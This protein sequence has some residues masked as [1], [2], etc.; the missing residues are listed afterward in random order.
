[1]IKVLVTLS[2]NQRKKIQS[3]Y[4]NKVSVRLYLSYEKIEK[5]GEFTLLLTKKQKDLIDTN[6]AVGKGAILELTYEQLERNHK[7]G[8]IQLLL[9]G[10]GAGSAIYSAIR[11][12]RHQAAEEEERK[13]HNAEMEKIA[14]SKKTLSIGSGLKE[15]KKDQIQPVSTL[16]IESL[17]KNLKINHFRYVF[18]K[19]ELPK[20]IDK[21][22]FGIINLEDSI[23]DGSHWTAYYK[24]TIKNIISILTEMLVLQN[25]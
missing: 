2:E 6:I 15:K 3:V 13:R 24:K 10:L 21:V 22:E 9:A 1:M 12:A 17:V 7:G 20:K 19:D 18:M 11:N 4:E 8:W 25:N 23:Q 5:S 16:D 14:Q